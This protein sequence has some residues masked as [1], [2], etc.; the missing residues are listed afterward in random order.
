MIN[1]TS[2]TD[3]MLHTEAIAGQ[4][5]RPAAPAPRPVDTDRLSASSQETLQAAL[6][7]QPE[8]RPEVVARGKEL[9]FNSMYP[10]LR[11]IEQLS[12]LLVKSHDLSE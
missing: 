2:K 3:S 11:I 4:V 12:E 7:K 10:P 5:P 8:I 9:A 1:T 6:S